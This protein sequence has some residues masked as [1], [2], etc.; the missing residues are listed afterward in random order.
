MVQGKG[1]V[2]M[3]VSVGVLCIGGLRQK[4]QVGILRLKVESVVV[5]G[6]VTRGLNAAVV[7]AHELQAVYV[8]G[9]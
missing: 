9:V 2:Q 4:L 8:E 7:V 1:G 5:G 3:A 6:I